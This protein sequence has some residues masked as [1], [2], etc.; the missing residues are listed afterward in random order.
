VCTALRLL[1]DSLVLFPLYSKSYMLA[2]ALCEGDGGPGLDPLDRGRAR[3]YLQRGLAACPAD[4][5]LW[6]LS[7]RLEERHRGTNKA[8]SLAELARL[9]LPLSD[10]VWLESIRLE[11]RA[12]ADR[13]AETLMA[14]ALKACPSSGLLWAEDVLAAGRG[15]QKQRSMEALKHCETS[16]L[17]V[18]AVARLFERD[19][20][21]EKARK[22]FERAVSL[23][24]SQGD[25]W[26]HWYAF[27]LRGALRG[28][29]E[30][31]ARAEAVLQRCVMATPNRG[32]LWC[33]TAKHTDMRHADP[34][35]VLRKVAEYILAVSDQGVAGMELAVEGW[36]RAADSMAS[37]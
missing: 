13:L 17:V 26:A 29:T 30:A 28:G 2:S 14:A 37:N 12:G 1:D 33:A 24:P 23:D 19:R 5:I 4:S 8:R 34:A 31:E 35:A 21:A 22:W 36:A 32:E 3:D 7:I 20:K 15:Q 6:R 9:R 16:P 11:R 10:E 27:E 18:C 25:S